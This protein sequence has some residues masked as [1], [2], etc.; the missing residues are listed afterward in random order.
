VYELFVIVIL[1]DIVSDDSE[2]TANDEDPGEN[3]QK[4]I[5]IVILF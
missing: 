5:S 1:H 2:H 3:I 4:N